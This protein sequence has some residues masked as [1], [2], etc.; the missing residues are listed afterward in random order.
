MSEALNRTDRITRADYLSMEDAAETR[1]EFIDGEIFAM[2]GGS[3]NHSIICVN[4]MWGLREAVSDRDCVAFDGNM[5]L[6][7][8]K[9]NAFVH[10]DGMVVCGAIEFVEGRNDIIRNPLLIVE[11]LSPATQA[12]DR[13]KKF[14]Y[15]R[16]I[17]SLQEY[18]MISQEEPLIEAYFRR[19][20]KTWLYTVIRG[21]EDQLVLSSLGDG[22]S[23]EEIYRKVDFE[24]GSGN[25][26]NGH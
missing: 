1:N 2:A 15:Y 16:T 19:D 22:I 26:S 13:G 21:L 18:V 9:E 8:E 4:L 25:D 6:N 11:V 12:F 23:L 17:P 14:K 7:I 20:E 3:R 10:P 24:G 5:K